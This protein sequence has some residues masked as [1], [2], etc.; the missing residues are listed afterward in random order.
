MNLASCR[1]SE[2]HQST[3]DNFYFTQTAF[4]YVCIDIIKLNL[5]G[6]SYVRIL[7]SMQFP[8]NTR[9]HKFDYPLYKPVEQ[10]LIFYFFSSSYENS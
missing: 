1:F 5:V 9:Y 7:T 2:G 3:I 4:V 8:S 6:D 10:T